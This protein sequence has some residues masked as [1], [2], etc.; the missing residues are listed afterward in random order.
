MVGVGDALREVSVIGH[1]KQPA[2]VEVQPADGRK[3]DA[4]ILDQIV[5]GRTSLG[6]F[7][8]RDIS[9]WLIQ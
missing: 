7:I 3:P 5:D 9:L 1:Q 6:I 4:G 8:S 2:G